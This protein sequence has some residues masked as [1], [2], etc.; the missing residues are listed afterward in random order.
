MPFTEAALGSF[1]KA[2]EK[3]PLR[4]V[5][6]GWRAY[7]LVVCTKSSVDRAWRVETAE[8]FKGKTSVVGCKRAQEAACSMARSLGIAFP[9][10]LPGGLT[11]IQPGPWA[12][13]GR[14]WAVQAVVAG[15]DGEPGIL[16]TVMPDVVLGTFFPGVRGPL[17]V[18]V[19][20]PP[21]AN[22]DHARCVVRSVCL[23]A[24]VWEHL[25]VVLREFQKRV[26]APAEIAQGRVVIKSDAS[27]DLLCN[28]G[29]AMLLTAS[30][31]ATLEEAYSAE[32]VSAL[33]TDDPLRAL[34]FASK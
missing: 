32:V 5:V 21:G 2:A 17:V 34:V 7:S 28:N 3:V 10:V 19:H 23:G 22:N 1:L 30:G 31:G 13:P 25:T 8:S 33:A 14:W 4:P 20:W 27:G 6:G 16:A 12:Q 9:A 18:I 11:W 29:A 26:L 15:H 24:D